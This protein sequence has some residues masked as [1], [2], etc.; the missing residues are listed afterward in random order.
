MDDGASVPVL[1]SAF[2]VTGVVGVFAHLERRAVPRGITITPRASFVTTAGR[3]VPV[4]AGT[5][6]LWEQIEMQTSW[7]GRL[8]AA[9]YKLP[10]V[11]VEV[12]TADGGT[13]LH[14][15][16]PAVSREGMLV[17]PLVQT[18][19]EFLQLMDGQAAGPR[20]QVTSLRVIV[21][22]PFAY[23]RD[24]RVRLYR[25]VIEPSTETLARSSGPRPVE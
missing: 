13:R 23:E 22:W 24:I 20:R 8:A 5:A 15:I 10:P 19:D 14:R 25:L 4:D 21:D 16:I 9:A 2:E 11:H 7:A 6:P 3:D 12:R 18:A 1:M 17:S